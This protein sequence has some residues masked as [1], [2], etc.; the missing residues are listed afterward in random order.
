VAITERRS[1]DD[2]DRLADAL[3]RAIRGG[4]GELLPDSGKQSSMTEEAPA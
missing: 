2:I 4:I 1:K 3:G